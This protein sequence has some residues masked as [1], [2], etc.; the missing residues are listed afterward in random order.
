MFSIINNL[1]ILVNIVRKGLSEKE[2]GF[3]AKLELKQKYFFTRDDIKNN[4]KNINEMN[5]YLYR[6][7]KKKRVVKLNRDKYFLIPIKAINSKWTEHPFIIIDEIM[8]NKDYCI[9]GKAAAYYWHFIEQ[10]PGEFDVYNKRI[11]KKVKIFN[12]QIDFRKK[13]KIPKGVKRKIYHHDFIISS[14]KEAQQW[15]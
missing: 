5:V 1:L 3:I 8:N 7:K 4:F 15:G 6:L 13:R 12:A 14:K 10:I 9:V 11:H 2:L